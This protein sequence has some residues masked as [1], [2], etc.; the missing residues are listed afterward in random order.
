MNFTTRYLSVFLG[1]CLVL[2]FTL[3]SKQGYAFEPKTIEAKDI[4]NETLAPV[5]QFTL[6]DIDGQPVDLKRFQGKVLLLVNT[7]SFCGNTPQYDGLQ[8]LYE[9]YQEK[10]FEIL[11]FPANNFGKQEPGTDE[12]IKSFCYTKYALDFPLFSKI[13]VKGEDTHPLYQYLTTQSPFPGEIEWN[14]QKFL[15]DRHGKVIAR[16]QPRLKPLSQQIV[17]EI[18]Q[19]LT[20]S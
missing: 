13:S 9:Q 7:A 6:N 2:S 19:A 17:S 16:F 18:E 8:T 11:A 15:V 12:E 5:Y 3:G 20:K 14:F 10:G 1:T 4:T